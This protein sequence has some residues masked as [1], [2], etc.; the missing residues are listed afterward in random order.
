MNTISISQAYLETLTI[1]DLLT[2]ANDYG[3][4]MPENLNKHFVIGEILSFLEDENERVLLH[5]DTSDAEILL[6]QKK[7]PFSYNETKIDVLIRN[8]A[9]IFVYWDINETDMEESIKSKLFVSFVLRVSFYQNVQSRTV[10]DS[11]DILV[12]QLDRKRYIFLSNPKYAFKI[13]LYAEFKNLAHKKLAQSVLY[14]VPKGYPGISANDLEMDC[15]PLSAL[16]GLADIRR[17]HFTNHR[18]SFA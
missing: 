10:I 4:D 18:Q 16:S 5:D 3:I 8:P 15:P 12:E 13:E 14:T 2:L 11:Y 7:L 9:W 1:A 17:I 6:E